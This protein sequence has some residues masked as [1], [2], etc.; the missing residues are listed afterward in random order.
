MSVCVCV[1]ACACACACLFVRACMRLCVCVATLNVFARK[2]VDQHVTLGMTGRASYSEI[3]SAIRKLDY[4]A[5]SPCNL[6]MAALLTF[7]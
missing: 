7:D 1:R 4:I 6:E 2:F 3:Y 5:I